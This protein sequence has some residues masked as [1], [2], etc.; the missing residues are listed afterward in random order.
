M[1]TALNMAIGAFWVSTLVGA[2]LSFKLHREIRG[3]YAGRWPELGRPGLLFN[4][5]AGG[6]AMLRWLQRRDYLEETDPSFVR[7]CNVVRAF[8]R[9]HLAL[10][11]IFVLLLA[12]T[13]T[14]A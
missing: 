6:I 13:M 10:F 14:T 11:L 4:S 5:Y 8:V 2:W 3:T 7:L 12:W 9:V 1:T